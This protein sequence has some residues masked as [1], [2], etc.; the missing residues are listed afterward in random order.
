[1]LLSYDVGSSDKALIHWKSCKFLNHW[2]FSWTSDITALYF[3]FFCSTPTN[4]L[5]SWIFHAT[6]ISEDTMLTIANER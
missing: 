4:D 5:Q 3:T 6:H 1:M 2:A